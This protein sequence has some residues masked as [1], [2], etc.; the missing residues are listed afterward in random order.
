M[1]MPHRSAGIHREI[2]VA[3]SKEERE[4]FLRRRGWSP[5]LPEVQKKEIQDYWG[6]DDAIEYAIEFGARSCGTVM[7]PSTSISTFDRRRLPGCFAKLG[8]GRLPLG[9][10]GTFRRPCTSNGASL[11]ESGT[12]VPGYAL[13]LTG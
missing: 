6:D 9:S 12:E 2:I 1:M 13:S 4:A 10:W 8:H 5:D 7:R 11:M 3:I